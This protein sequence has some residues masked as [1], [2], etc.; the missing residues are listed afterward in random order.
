MGKIIDTLHLSLTLLRSDKRRL[1]ATSLGLLIATILFAQLLIFTESSRAVIFEEFLEDEQWDYADLSIYTY[2][3][4]SKGEDVNSSLLLNPS[5]IINQTLNELD[6]DLKISKHLRTIYSQGFSWVSN[7]TNWS[8]CYI[9]ACDEDVFLRL[10]AE[11]SLT[12]KSKLPGE[13]EALLITRG[14]WGEEIDSFASIGDNISFS[15]WDPDYNSAVPNT[16]I[17]IVGEMKYEDQM[18]SQ[19]TQTLLEAVFGYIGDIA[20]VVTEETFIQTYQNFGNKKLD[21]W[22]QFSYRELLLYDY[23]TI[24]P[25][26]LNEEAHKI[27]L[28][29]N[30]LQTKF[31]KAN[32]LY[33]MDTP[34]KENMKKFEETILAL[35]M[36]MLLYSFP[37]LGIAAFLVVYSYG[38]VKPQMKQRIGILKT[39]GASSLQVFLFLGIELVVATGT[40]VIAGYFIA[41]PF[42]GIITRTSGF[43]DFNK[44][45]IPIRTSFRSFLLVAGFGI[46]LALLLNLRS[47]VR[48]SNMEIQ[49][50][51][52]RVEK[53]LPFWKRTYLDVFLII[54]GV[55]GFILIHIAQRAPD[56]V[57]TEFLS[58]IGVPSPFLLTIGLVLL[59]TRL[60][61]IFIEKLGNWSWT[62][63][64]GLTSLAIKNLVQ[65][66]HPATRA[67]LL[68]TM[69]LAFGVISLSLPVIISEHERDSLYYE[70][71]SDIKISGLSAPNNTLRTILETNYS[72]D[73]EEISS[74]ARGQI[75]SY[76]NEQSS[77]PMG[78]QYEYMSIRILGID[79][80]TFHKVRRDKT[81]LGTK[82]SLIELKD[83]LNENNNSVLIHKENM[84]ALKYSIGDNFTIFL[85]SQKEELPNRSNYKINTAISQ[86]F[87]EY[88]ILDYFSFWPNLYF[89]R[90]TKDEALWTVYLI[91]NLST[92]ETLIQ[93]WQT[94]WDWYDFQYGYVIKLRDPTKGTEIAAELRE[95]TDNKI[96]SFDNEYTSVKE[97]PQFMFWMA[98]INSNVIIIAIVST[99]AILLFAFM[100]LIERSKEIGVERTLGMNLKQTAVTFLIETLI[101]LIFGEITGLILGSVLTNYFVMITYL[102]ENIPPI[103]IIYPAMWLLGGLLILTTFAVLAAAIPAYLATQRQIS[104]ILKTE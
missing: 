43:M 8:S 45:M 15:A 99:I 71:V 69:T 22:I 35:L 37:L 31:T 39:R 49:E 4:I 34:I 97:G 67:V 51:E 53:R 3:D 25:F 84:K 26:S 80:A 32:F 23:S 40:A 14:Y 54:I 59:T 89:D 44:S 41:V 16:S 56:T 21:N 68:I 11:E 104:D 94:S 57:P 24:D 86:E 28:L 1:F 46:C 30:R 79:P 101:I 20:L 52:V 74:Y 33:Y 76:R 72:S 75:D 29:D 61:P 55:L 50:M 7:K 58:I 78:I 42:S 9:C 87:R 90:I 27:T 12:A 64:G 2:A 77:E 93:F 6:L 82:N 38:L 95:I 60:F 91:M 10:E 92:L 5:T 103:R 88:Q 19:D 36:F 96:E 83:A 66:K 85:P 102:G 48:Y 63:F 18:G 13:M 81:D 17:S 73:I 62:K 70:L 98:V 65:R 100:Q 47:L